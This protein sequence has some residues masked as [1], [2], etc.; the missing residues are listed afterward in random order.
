MDEAVMTALNSKNVT[1]E[2]L[3]EAVKAQI[4]R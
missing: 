1:Q 4:R 2:G 3:L